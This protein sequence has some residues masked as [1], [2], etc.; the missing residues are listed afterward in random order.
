MYSK[1]GHCKEKDVTVVYDNN[2]VEVEVLRANPNGQSCIPQPMRS[3]MGHTGSIGERGPTGENGLIGVRG[4]TGMMGTMGIN[5]LQGT[6]GDIGPTGPIGVFGGFIKEDILPYDNSVLSIGNTGAHFKRLHCETIYLSGKTIYLKDIPIEIKN[7]NL[8]LPFGTTI[9]EKS[10]GSIKVLGK[11]QRYED[12]L[13]INKK[14][15]G[16]SYIIDE[17][18]WIYNGISFVNTGAYNGSTGPTGPA[19]MGEQGLQGV[20]GTTGMIGP[21]GITGQIGPEYS[22][23]INIRNDDISNNYYSLPDNKMHVYTIDSSF[24]FSMNPDISRNGISN[25]EYVKML[26]TSQKEIILYNEE[27][28]T[29]IHTKN[30]FYKQY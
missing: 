17:N 16:D 20:T 7:G 21:T 10:I 8:N 4:P 18:L 24:D 19:G 22:L 15:A 1:S 9:N 28:S 5:G 23:I 2:R 26:T 12:L 29:M 11:I 27:L 13:V 3:K 6:R 30:G 25:N 14:E